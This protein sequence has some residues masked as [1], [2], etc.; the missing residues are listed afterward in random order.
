[1]DSDDSASNIRMKMMKFKNE[2][3]E[4]VTDFNNVFIIYTVMTV[5]IKRGPNATADESNVV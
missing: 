2:N 1:V 4:Y 3:D 5:K